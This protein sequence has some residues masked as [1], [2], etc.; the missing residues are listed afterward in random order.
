[1]PDFAVDPSLAGFA[2][3]A[4]LYS[5][6]A[7]RML[8][9][10]RSRVRRQAW[11]PRGFLAAVVCSAAW[12]AVAL[13]ASIADLDALPPAAALLDV[14]RYGLWFVFLLLLVAPAQRAEPR[15]EAR[16][17][18]PVAVV[19][20]VFSGITL[21]LAVADLGGAPVTRLSQFGALALPLLGLMLI[22]QLFRNLPEDSRWN[23]KPLCLGLGVMF[24]FDLY[25]YSEAVLFGSFDPDAVSIR[26]AIHALAVPLLFV[27]SGRHRDWI[28]KLQVSRTAAFYSAT[29]LL[30]G[31]YLLFISAIGYYV[32]YFGG[33]WG[34]AL[35]ITLLVAAVVLLTLLVFSGTWRAKLRVFVSKNFFSYRYDYREQWLR[36]TAMLST[37]SSPQEMSGLIVRGLADLVESPGGILWSQSA[38]DARFMPGARWNMALIEDPVPV[39][40]ELARFV[41]E[42]NWI[43]DIDEWRHHPERYD[44]LRL[45]PAL[46]GAEQAWVLVPL[47]VADALTG[48]VVLARPR[49]RLELNWEVRDLLK[50]AS[51]QAA[52]FLAQMQATEA[53]L[54][55]RKF[56]AFNRMSA[57]V[58]HDLKNIVTQLTLMMKNAKRL[59]D[60]AEFQQDMLMT[61][62]SSLEKMRQLILQLREGEKPAGG[63]AGVDLSAIAGRLAQVAAQRG[64]KLELDLQ[65]RVA[66]RGHEERVERVLGHMVQN[67]FDATPPEGRVWL[68]LSRATGQAR[69]E[70]GDTGQ[71]MSREF[72]EREL[73][74]PFRTT[75]QGGMGIGSYESWQ[76]V[77]ELGGKIAVDSEPGRGTLITIE[78]PLLEMRQASDLTTV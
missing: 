35:Q 5:A 77:R 61:V 3:A 13:A 29:L 16:F 37:R 28:G 2:V 34:R 46:A 55:A 4:A 56:D 57:F 22:E 59:H 64:R 33:S 17:L 70:I 12:A 76:Y 69:V 23:A 62:E 30:S 10:G 73:F 1:M 39:D 60:N 40:S 25:I 20:V 21:P 32:R 38:G 68:R 19:L 47:I 31:L 54:E 9:S 11:A 49:T 48:F 63:L 58:V 8:A 43:V 41:L 42:R 66:T 52:S 72:V 71:G 45:P 74:R 67:A 78:L 51:R 18:P 75:K 50:T 27:A 24:L 14:L 26:G 36:F 15:S 65:D 7:V 6:L 44:G 53:L